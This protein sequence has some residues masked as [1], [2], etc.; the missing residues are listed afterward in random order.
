M[1]GKAMSFVSNT[2]L[3]TSRDPLPFETINERSSFP[4]AIICEHAGRAVPEALGSL[5]L[6]QAAMERHIAW[7]IGAGD[8]TQRLAKR[9]GATAILQ[10]YSR[11]VID[12]N[13]P[14]D[15]A[16]SMPEISDHTP[17]PGNAGLD[18]G[19]RRSRIEAI[20]EPFHRAVDAVLDNGRIRAAVAIHSF[21]P[22]MNDEPRP[23]DI[24]FLSRKDLETSREL[25][26]IIETRRPDLTI[27]FNQPY[28]IEDISDWFIPRH[29]ERRGLPHSL[30]EIR[31]D[32]LLSDHRIDDWC[33]LLADAIT[34]LAERVTCR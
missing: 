10:P 30:I 31:N 28:Q 17:I 22:V 4:V 9:L 16:D 32:H 18:D 7:D 2:S 26:S 29:C 19:D 8:L 13:R 6:D 33:D 14:T 25:A 24:S 15:V 27:G 3:L 21:T 11:L 5:G 1:L 23:W 12:C 20:F 34:T